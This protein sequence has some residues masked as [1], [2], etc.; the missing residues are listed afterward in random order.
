MRKKIEPEKWPIPG[1]PRR[2]PQTDFTQL[3]D[4]PEFV[5]GQAFYS[6]TGNS[7]S[8]R[9]NNIT[10]GYLVQFTYVFKIYLDLIGNLKLTFDTQNSIHIA[11]L[12]VL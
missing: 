11:S 4:C 7:F 5:P 10:V 8:S 1:P 9:A 6:H 2:V 3:I 12:T